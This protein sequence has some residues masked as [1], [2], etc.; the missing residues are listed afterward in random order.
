MV[1]EAQK[2]TDTFVNIRMP[3]ALVEKLDHLKDIRGT[4][5]TKEVIRAVEFLVDAKTCTK[6]GA[7]NPVN[8]VNCSVCGEKLINLKMLRYEA[9]R[10]IRDK[11]VETHPEGEKDKYVV[12]SFDDGNGE[13]FEISHIYYD[14][15]G[16]VYFNIAEKDILIP[17]HQI[18]AELK[19]MG[20]KLD[21]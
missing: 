7:L 21:L 5:R 1:E 3:N 8:G 16:F 11:F 2:T 17:N 10:R 4:N 18:D 6:C 20:Y 13:Q 9:A 15:D 14:D 12:S 19:K